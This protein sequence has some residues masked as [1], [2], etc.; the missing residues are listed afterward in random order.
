[1]NTQ[2]LEP[3][4]CLLFNN[5]NI[6][7]KMIYPGLFHQEKE[8]RI[9]TTNFLYFYERINNYNIDLFAVEPK[10]EC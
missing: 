4:L 8:V 2:L 5:L 9:L 1:M 7:F 10:E 3:L 6:D